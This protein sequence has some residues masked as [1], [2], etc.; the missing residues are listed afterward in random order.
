MWHDTSGIVG[1]PTQVIVY[2]W[3][4][5]HF[6]YLK[7]WRL[8]YL[9]FPLLYFAY[10]YA[11]VMPSAT[12]PPSQKTGVT[13][14]AYLVLIQSSTSLITSVVTPSQILLSNFSSPHPSALGR[15]HSITFFT[16]MAVRA[17][18]SAMAGNLHAYGSTHNLTGLV[19][20]ISSAVSLVGII[21]SQFVK[22]SNGHEIKLPGDD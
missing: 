20:W 16:S 22:E 13:V 9:G 18:G 7:L 19:F 1:I 5:N 10:P 8:F 14:W 3:L 17:A 6:G 15:T 21:A 12:P 2:P 11:A 4:N